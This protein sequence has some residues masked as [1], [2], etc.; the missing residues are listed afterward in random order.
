[1]VELQ[2]KGKLTRNPASVRV[3]M[4]F[5]GFSTTYFKK[6]LEVNF[7][8]KENWGIY[9]PVHVLG[10]YAAA[11]SLQSCPTPCDPIDDSPPGSPVPRMGCHFLLQCMKVK[12][13]S[14]V[15]QS[16]PTPSDP[17]DR[18]PTRLLRPWDFPGKSTGVGCHC[19]LHLKVQGRPKIWELLL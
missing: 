19:L 8:K 14:E 12:S 11:Q 4:H 18:K 17:M 13:E 2:E 7:L 6:H 1:M 3:L 10:G 5:C 15:A 16:C 9:Y